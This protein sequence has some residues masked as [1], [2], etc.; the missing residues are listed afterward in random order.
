MK[1]EL[2][3]EGLFL[4]VW[5]TNE[6]GNKVYPHLKGKRNTTAKG[7]DI[8]LTAKKEDY[9]LVSVEKFIDHITAGDFEGK[10]RVRM[11]EPGGKDSSGF[12]VLKSNMSTDMK[13]LLSKV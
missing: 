12:S 4:H 5:A 11:K 7:I 9:H 1:L 3:E 13:A 6:S 8:T 10:G 2:N